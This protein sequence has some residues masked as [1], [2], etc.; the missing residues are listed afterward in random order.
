MVLV[1][2]LST[3]AI[4]PLKSSK[5]AAGYDLFSPETIKLEAGEKTLIP[6]NLAFEM[7]LNCY[8]RIAEKSSLS[9]RSITVHAGVIDADFRGNVGVLL[10]NWSPNTLLIKARTP[11]A[12][13]IFEQ[14][15]HPRLIET[16]CLKKN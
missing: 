7:P 9:V 13:I 12:Q 3:N 15:L 14:I 8:G 10:S 16:N 11:I 1:K 6:L 4:I 5:Y 2:K